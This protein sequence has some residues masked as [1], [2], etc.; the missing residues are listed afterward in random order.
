MEDILLTQWLYE[1]NE[2]NPYDGFP[3]DAYTVDLQGWGFQS[4]I[5]EHVIATYRP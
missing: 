3:L 4:A 2:K 5:F 1:I